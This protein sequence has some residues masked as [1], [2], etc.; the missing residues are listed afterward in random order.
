MPMV[1]DETLRDG[2]QSASVLDP[3]IEAK[4]G[5]L[6]AMAALGV[7]VVSVGLPAA[8]ARAEADAARLA[9]EI[10]DAKL[11]MIP[12]GAARTTKKDVYAVA[13]AAERAGT[14][15]EVY[16][17]IGT[18]PI[19]QYVENWDM[20]FLLSHIREACEAARDAGLPFCLVTEDTTRTPPA[21]IAQL[22]AAAVDAG[23][24]RLCLCDTVGHADP[25]GTKALV[26]FVKA[27]LVGLG[28]T[29]VGLDWHGHNDR[30]LALGNAIAA[31]QAGVGRVHG[32]ALGLGERTGNARLEHL[33]LALESM[34]ARTVR[35]AAAYEK[36]EGLAASALGAASIG[37]VASVAP[38]DVAIVDP[39]VPARAAR[40]AGEVAEPLTVMTLRV[41]GETVQIA[42]RPSRTLLELLRY[43]LDLIATKQGCDKGDCGACTVMVNG[44][45][46]LSCL[47][48]ALECDGADVVT[49]ESLA[50]GATPDPLI[51]A[52]D[53]FGASQCGFCT[54]G[55][56]MSAK[57]LLATDPHPSTDT[58]RR[59]ISG[60]LCRCTGY[61]PIVKAIEHAANPGASPPDENAPRPG[62][63]CMPA[64]IPRHGSRG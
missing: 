12:T 7:D 44:A 60:N 25:N 19:R 10:V 42:T 33:L 62:T 22:Y 53:R 59:A 1:V 20:D 32:T 43:D 40:D 27:T 39:L 61:G 46:V 16:A 47:T 2:L 14:P 58:V 28:A 24:S 50:G 6:H 45:A 63:E 11:G 55:M 36:F 30:G 18:S 21:A 57:A 13:R 4:I 9:R 51:E 31:V 64:P 49:C 38:P 35:P 5:L 29:H 15:I 26:E 41:N 37:L 34:G 54:P 52:F 8:G 3:S 23:A 48:L 56:L 17:F